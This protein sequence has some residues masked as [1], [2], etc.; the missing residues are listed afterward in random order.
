MAHGNVVGYVK[1]NPGANRLVLV[2]ILSTDLPINPNLSNF[3]QLS[4]V[5][6]GLFYLHGVG[7]VLGDLKGVCT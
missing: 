4:D 7:L 3:F 5:A 6:N 2:I 1:A